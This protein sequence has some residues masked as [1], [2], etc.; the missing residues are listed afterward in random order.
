MSVRSASPPILMLWTEGK[1]ATFRINSPGGEVDE[2]FAMLSL[3]KK[4]DG[5]AEVVIDGLCA[6]AATLLAVGRKNDGWNVSMSE[7]GEFMVHAPWGVCIGS[8]EEMN[9]TGRRSGNVSK[10]HRQNL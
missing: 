10:Q 6:S 8:A 4:Y 3:M 9:E 1:K 7:F 5:E 2:A